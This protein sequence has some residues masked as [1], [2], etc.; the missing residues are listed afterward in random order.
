MASWTCPHCDRQF[1]RRNQSH[2]CAPALS[3]DDKTVL[4]VLLSRVVRHSRIARVYEGSGSRAAHFI[5][6]RTA[7]DVDD[8]VRNWLTEGYLA[9]PP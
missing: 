2:E 8:D 5:D 3:L 9:S 4:S 1:G 6:L 7:E